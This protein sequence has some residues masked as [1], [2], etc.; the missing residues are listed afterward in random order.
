MFDDVDN[1]CQA[2]GELMANSKTQFD[3]PQQPHFP[4]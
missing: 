4:N 3:F 2:Y 1:R